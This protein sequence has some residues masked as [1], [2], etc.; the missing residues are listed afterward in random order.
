MRILMAATG[1]FAVPTFLALPEAGHEVLALVT[2]PDRPSGRGRRVTASRIKDAALRGGVPVLQPERIATQEMTDR[3]AAIAP[4]VF[5][6]IAYGQ[7]IPEAICNLPPAGALNLHGSLLPAL[8]GAAPC[9]WA[10]V[11][12]LKETGVT[13]QVLAQTM[14]AGDV[15][16]ARRVAVGPRETAPELHDRLAVLGSELVLDVLQQL[17]RGTTRPVKQDESRVTYAPR[18]KKEDGL[19][20]WASS[21]GEIDSQVRG[22]MP[23]PGAYSYLG[24]PGKPDLRIILGEVSPD[25]EAA[26]HEAAPG[27]V[28]ESRKR[29]VVAAGT[30]VVVVN[31]LKPQSGKV[32]SG[33]AFC[34]GHKVSP[35]D[36]LGAQ[37][38]VS[39]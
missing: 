5:L 34:N 27:T 10:I 12:G 26:E 32:M 6:V 11:R 25:D 1:D 18:L 35:G 33:V 31:H 4:E 3:L 22:M 39:Q 24:H 20:D 19:I 28:I 15:L 17:D 7:K 21:A 14:D 9:N 29:L 2:Q 13:V 30:G 23:W 37:C 16:A 36:V 8:R 38:P